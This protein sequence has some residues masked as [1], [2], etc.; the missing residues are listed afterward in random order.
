MVFGYADYFFLPDNNCVQLVQM[1]MCAS[2]SGTFHH[3]RFRHLNIEYLHP[4]HRDP[5]L[6]LV[7]GITGREL[8]ELEI[9]LLIHRSNTT[10]Y[11]AM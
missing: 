9:Y 3:D 1:W 4:T 11:L 7:H 10:Y 2:C 8:F 6:L 5:I